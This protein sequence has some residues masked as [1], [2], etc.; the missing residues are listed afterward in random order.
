LGRVHEPRAQAR[1][2]AVVGSQRA[3]GTVSL[4]VF[5]LGAASLVAVFVA[6]QV[7]LFE[8]LADFSRAH[9][10]WELDE[11]FSS[12]IAFSLF[13]SVFAVNEVRSLHAEVAERRRLEAELRELA[14]YDPLTQLPNRRLALELAELELRHAA[15][16]GT[17]LA[18]VFVDVD[19]FKEVNDSFGHDTGDQVLMDIAQS[20]S[21]SVRESD[22]VGR[23]AGDEFVVILAGLETEEDAELA[24]RKVVGG[25]THD[26]LGREDLPVKLSA[27]I[28]TYPEAG[29]SVD[30]LLRAADE[31]MYAAKRQ[32]EARTASQAD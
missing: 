15:R 16:E 14:F 25:V 18:V 27:G 21:R 31:E 23:L 32:K 22:V 4:D 1:E 11:I 13:V 24:A 29:G 17:R 6:Y 30:A 5:L 8:I 7:D 9:E 20:L 19:D 12:L 28:A 10:Q 26:L 2:A 3:G